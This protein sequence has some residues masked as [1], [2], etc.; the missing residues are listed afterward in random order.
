M[1]FILGF[2]RAMLCGIT[3]FYCSLF[4]IIIFN[5]LFISVAEAGEF[6]SF[7]SGQLISHRIV[8]LE[9]RPYVKLVDEKIEY[10]SQD[11]K[12]ALVWAISGNPDIS[13]FEIER[14]LDN[15]LDFIKIGEYIP[16][17]WGSEDMQF[18]FEDVHVPL[19]GGRIYYRI[20]QVDVNGNRYFGR[21]LSVEVSPSIRNTEAVWRSY[22]NPSKNGDFQIGLLDKSGYS[23]EPISIRII[24]SGNILISKSYQ[25]VDDINRFLT[26]DLKNISSGLIVIE[27]RWG[28]QSQFLKIWNLR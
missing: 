27:L 15:K 25:D 24:Q 11:R 14:A 3:K 19:A 8:N 18:Q 7:S 23:G 4:S 17:H 26:Q 6:N 21:T 20:K 2:D 12:V 28:F 9:T 16:Q 5:G 13:H 1:Y 22:P 10:S